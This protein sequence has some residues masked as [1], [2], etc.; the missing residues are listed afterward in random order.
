[1]PTY[2]KQLSMCD[3]QMELNLL[4]TI[5]MWNFEATAK[6]Y[7]SGSPTAVQAWRTC[8]LWEPSPSH[9]ILL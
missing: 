3:C 1:M 9:P 5:V 8:P 6:G 4:L 2:Y 7:R